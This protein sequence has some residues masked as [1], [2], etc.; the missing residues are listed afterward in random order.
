MRIDTDW[1]HHTFCSC[2]EACIDFETL[3]KEN[4]ELGLRDFGVSDHLHAQ[5]TEK[6][7]AA[8]RKEYERA[9]AAHPELKGHFHFGVEA[10]VMSAWELEKIAKGGYEDAAYGIRE[11]GP[12]WGPLALA[13]DDAFM[14]KYKVDYVITSVH[15][16]MYC[17]LEKNI[18]VKDYFR[19]CMFAAT[20]PCTTILG[21]FLWWNPIRGME[22]PFLDFS[23]ITRSMREELRA[24]LLECNAAFEINKDAMLIAMPEAFLDEYLGWIADMQH[25]GVKIAFGSDNHSAHVGKKSFEKADEL[26]KR[27]QIDASE[28]F[29]L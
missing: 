21:H 13:L 5:P 6:D 12:A 19:Q 9:M 11:G 26:L 16:P 24:A 17:E 1:H 29:R 27:Y 23:V 10:S 28:F 18:F 2:D 15:W 22:N 3:I 25:S 4:A 14:E 7:I 20:H 8:S